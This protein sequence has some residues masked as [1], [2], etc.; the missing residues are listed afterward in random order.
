M[1]TL[2]VF[3]SSS[4]VREPYQV[5]A[6]EVGEWMGKSGRKLI[7]GGASVGLMGVVADAT[8]AAGGEVKGVIPESLAGIREL[9]H[10]GLSEL[11][12]VPDLF[13][14]KNIMNE[15]ADGFVVLPG[16]Y[17]TLDEALEVMTWRQLGYHDKP[18][19]F[20]NVEG[21]WDHLL[22]FFKKM[23]DEKMVSQRSLDLFRV[24]DSLDELEA[25]LS[26]SGE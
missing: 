12:V 8:L 18:I 7:Y 17:G 10:T 9:A 21:F 11:V 19:C 20:Y 23:Y 4:D 1:K 26:R 5:I 25:F 14:R 13:E 16:G 2:T 3:C 24:V 15:E 6:R 22:D